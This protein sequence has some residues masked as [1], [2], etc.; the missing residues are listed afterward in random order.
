MSLVYETHVANSEISFISK[1][2]KTKHFLS[3]KNT[4][5]LR[6]ERR[7]H[8]YPG[9]CLW[10]RGSGHR[11]GL[12]LHFQAVALRLGDGQAALTHLLSC[13]LVTCWLPEGQDMPQMGQG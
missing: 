1:G 7:A 11:A 12:S 8:Q 2:T 10:G 5:N 3:V 4:V 9:L 6:A 13:I